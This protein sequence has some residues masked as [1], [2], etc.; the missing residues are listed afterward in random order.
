MID[1][2]GTRARFGVSLRPGHCFNY[3]SSHRDI[4]AGLDRGDLG[5]IQ[6][7]GPRLIRLSTVL[8]LPP[9]HVKRDWTSYF[10]LEVDVPDDFLAD[11]DDSPP[12]SRE[13][14]WWPA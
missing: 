13:L 10:A 1:F 5:E 3:S 6:I 11:R 8:G 14:S 9:S 12:Q 2:R 4:L 7:G